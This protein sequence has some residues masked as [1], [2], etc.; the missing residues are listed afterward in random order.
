MIEWIIGGLIVDSYVDYKIRSA[1]EASE[2]KSKEEKSKLFVKCRL[3]RREALRRGYT[4]Q[5]CICGTCS[6]RKR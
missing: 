4:K 2:K 1:K 5:Q 3:K 6:T